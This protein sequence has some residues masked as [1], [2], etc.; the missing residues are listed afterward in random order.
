MAGAFSP[1][2]VTIIM[3]SYLVICIAGFDLGL[4]IAAPILGCVAEQVGYG[5]M[6]GYGAV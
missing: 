4:A 5:N 1:N 3:F 2:K 6:F